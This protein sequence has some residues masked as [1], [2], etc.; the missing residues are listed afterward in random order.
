VA[1]VEPW[2]KVYIDLQGKNSPADLDIHFAKLSCSACHKGDA[3]KGNNMDEAHSGMVADPSDP[4]H[5]VCGT[6][7]CHESTAD[8]FK[9]SLHRQ[10]WGEKHMLALR[11]G[12]ASF[13]QCPV[14]LKNG[15]NGECTLCHA[16]CGD[17]HISVPN[18]AGSGLVNGHQFNQTP[19]MT[20]NCTA[21]HGSRIGAEYIANEDIGYLGDV[22]YKKG[23]FTCTVSGCHDK[24]EMH[25]AA[26]EGTDRYHYNKL[27][28]CNWC[29]HEQDINEVNEYHATHIEDLSCQVCHA[30][31]Y[32]NCASCHVNGAYKTDDEYQKNNPAKAFKIGRNPLPERGY[33][34][35][36]L[37]HIP[38]AR[39]TYDNWEGVSG[40][41][42][43][44]D[45]YPTWKYA[46]SHSIQRFTARTDTSGGKHCYMRC[47]L[48]ADPENQK[49][50]LF[51]S[52]IQEKWP[53]EVE[54]NKEV[55]V[56]GYLPEGWE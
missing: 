53:D 47:H 26:E 33:K 10:L 44:Y 13:D 24:Y 48:N 32:N 36:T 56:D 17:C 51:E 35:V 40:P 41:L 16:S 12:S 27:P 39:D 7:G 29:H 34:F 43:A 49:Y 15:Y 6:A 31:D 22:H 1:P 19:D 5:D 45:E 25:G 54:A 38:I 46:T 23:R 14:P 28:S 52:D 20:Q 37:R 9:S 3:S 55:V 50:Y 30:Q 8:N 42:T 2:Q 18:S 21:C 11:T 4:P